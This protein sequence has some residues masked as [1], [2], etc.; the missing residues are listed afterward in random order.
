L[1]GDGLSK[2]L[3]E[4]NVVI[5]SNGSKSAEGED[6]TSQ[7]GWGR[8]KFS[9]VN[10]GTGDGTAQGAK[11]NEKPNVTDFYRRAGEG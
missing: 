3:K 4:K 9:R 1:F 8:E 6:T 11:K 10:K 2:D 7:G 5:H